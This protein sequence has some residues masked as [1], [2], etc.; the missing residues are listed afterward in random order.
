ML[1]KRL[2]EIVYEAQAPHIGSALSVLNIL[3]AIYDSVDVE[4]IRNKAVDRDRIILSKGHAVSSLWMILN[5]YKLLSDEELK[6]YYKN[7]SILMGHPS[8]YHNA[9]E[10]STGA[11]G[12]GLPISAGIA[13]GLKRKGIPA[14]VYCIVGDGEMQEGS[15][16]E[17]LM[18]I[19]HHKLDNI[20][21]FIDRNK[22]GGSYP[23]DDHCSLSPLYDKLASFGL[24]TTEIDGH[25]EDEL[26]FNIRNG[27][28]SGN[29]YAIICNT[30][31]GKGVSFMEDDNVWH[32]RPV[33]K[34]DYERAL[35]E[36]N[37]SN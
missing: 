32:Y 4:K 24:M 31:K 23:I 33:C 36:L 16:W 30:I 37:S 3:S 15:N 20:G 6:T 29:P 14:K 11:L 25:N 2:L 12:H 10:Y 7:G 34:T 35:C 19:G 17:A 26:R 5:K 21:V 13:L 9:I 1:K 22:Y 28:E 27:N 8:Y 18:L